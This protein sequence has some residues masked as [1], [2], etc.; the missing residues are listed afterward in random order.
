M[1]VVTMGNKDTSHISIFREQA[2]CGIKI[3][4]VNKII[5]KANTVR[6]G[7]NYRVHHPPDG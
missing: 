2:L 6:E 4:Y 1:V 5:V 3:T 7:I